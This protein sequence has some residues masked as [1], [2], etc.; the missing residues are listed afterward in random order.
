MD[1]HYDN[2]PAHISLVVRDFLAKNNIVIILQL[3]RFFST[4]KTEKDQKW[5]EIWHDGGEKDFT[6]GRAEGHMN[7]CIS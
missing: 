3:L 1:L 5:M 6:T 7:N 4:S 2:L